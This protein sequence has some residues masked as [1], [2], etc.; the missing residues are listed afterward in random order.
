MW[1]D[2]E[3]GRIWNMGGYGIWEDM[4]VWRVG[5]YE[6]TYSRDVSSFHFG[7]A[8]TLSWLFCP[9]ACQ[10]LY[11]HAFSPNTVRLSLDRSYRVHVGNDAHIPYI[12]N[13]SV[14]M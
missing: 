4:G 6:V 13:S 10:M 12:L 11:Y 1:E 14:M 5:E 2:M 8:C 3:Y 7:R 9:R